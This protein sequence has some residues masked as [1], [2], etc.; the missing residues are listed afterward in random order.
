MKH[1]S[2]KRDCFKYSFVMKGV[3]GVLCVLFGG[4]EVAND[5]GKHTQ[6]KSFVITS[7]HFKNMRK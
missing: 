6:L 5:K 1:L 4:G 2:G 3:L 7:S